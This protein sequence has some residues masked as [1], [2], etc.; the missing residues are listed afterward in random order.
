[1]PTNKKSRSLEEIEAEIL[2]LQEEARAIREAEIAEVVD[3][4]KRAI[5]QYGLTA[6]DLGLTLRQAAGKGKKKAVAGRKMPAA[7]KYRDEAGNSWSGRGKRPAWFR[8]A[9]AAGKSADQFLV[10]A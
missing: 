8:E 2:R 7:V 6:E 10:G 3:N 4:V 9:L 1:M 5:A